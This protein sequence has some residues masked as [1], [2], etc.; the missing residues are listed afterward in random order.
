VLADTP[1]MDELNSLPYLDAVV[2]ESLRLHP[3]VPRGVRVAVRDDVLPV[4]ELYLDKYGVSHTSI[5]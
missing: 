3:P 1:S 5:P 4:S 2:R